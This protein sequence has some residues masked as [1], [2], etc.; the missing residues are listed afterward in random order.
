[1]V[2]VLLFGNGD[3]GIETRIRNDNPCVVAHVR[4]IN[5][6]TKERMSNGFLESNRAGPETNHWV[7]LSNIVGT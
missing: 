5:S 3:V 4:P 1:M 7:D 6:V 2:S